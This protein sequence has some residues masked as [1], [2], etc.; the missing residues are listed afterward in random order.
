MQALKD[1]VKN[2]YAAA[3][4]HGGGLA[5]WRYLH[6]DTAAVGILGYHRIS[7]Q[8]MDDQLGRLKRHFRFVTLDDVWG[9]VSGGIPLR[10]DCL[11]L[12]FDDGH[13][14]FYREVFPVLQKHNCPA[15][16]FVATGP[17]DNGELL[18]FDKVR[19][20]VEAGACE[21]LN[22]GRAAVPLRDRRAAYAA[23]VKRL[24]AMGAAQRHAIV[25]ELFAAAS[26]SA[27]ALEPH[28]LM[29]W[30]MIRQMRGRVTFGAHTVTHPDLAA[31][32][33]EEAMGEIASSKDRLEAQLQEPVR[34]FAYPFGDRASF[35]AQTAALAARA[36]LQLAV[37]TLRGRC[38]RG[39]DPCT[40]PRILADGTLSG[41]VLAARLSGLWWFVST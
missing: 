7:G 20:A 25:A 33:E 34:F 31:M 1:L 30:D 35:N 6:A 16:M 28:R 38:R 10:D 23:S 29:T 27:Q 5:A 8:A 17:V 36:G 19:V 12:T 11:A 21:S 9:H 13:E 14:S 15:A 32:G 24:R 26:P 4:W 2:V 40:L 3:L 37:T 22:V 41:K 39:D 18:W